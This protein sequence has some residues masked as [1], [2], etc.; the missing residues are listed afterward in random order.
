MSFNSLFLRF[1]RRARALEQRAQR[2][3]NSLFLRFSVRRLLELVDVASFQFSLLEILTAI[4][5]DDPRTI[6]KL[7]ILSS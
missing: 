6:K 3:F 1:T 4:R 7:S 5:G 2:A